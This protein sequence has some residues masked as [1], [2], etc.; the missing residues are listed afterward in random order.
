ML[1][2]EA[3][4]TS[5]HSDWTGLKYLHMHNR[6]GQ[7]LSRVPQGAGCKQTAATVCEIHMPC[8]IMHQQQHNLPEA[9]DG[10][11]GCWEVLDQFQIVCVSV[12]VVRGK[13]GCTWTWACLLLLLCWLCTVVAAQTAHAVCGLTGM[14]V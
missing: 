11:E 13:L 6:I 9:E 10:L 7:L 8:V 14:T 4:A 12:W 2:S 1:T 5:K 3:L